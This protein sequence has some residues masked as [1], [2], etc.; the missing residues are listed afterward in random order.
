MN[1]EAYEK[2]EDS[3]R[4]AGADLYPAE[5]HGLL[6]GLLCA[7]APVAADPWIDQVLGETEDGDVLVAECRTTLLALHE[8]T[9]AQIEDEELDFA[10]VL[11][12]DDA[13]LG[14][15]AVALG[16]WCQSFVYGL[17]ASGVGAGG[18]KLPGDAGELLSDLVEISRAGLGE[19]DDLEEEEAAY[20]E[21]EEYVRVGVLL[22][23]EELRGK[24]PQNGTRH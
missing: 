14:T 16:D 7:A 13:T 9:S 15:R 1:A 10:L 12:G 23:N 2:F 19:D 22:I 8:V 21:L 18:E 17:A 5:A 11:P 24:R 6:C 20:A 4:R 3:L